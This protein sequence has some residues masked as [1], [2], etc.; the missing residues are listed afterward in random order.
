MKVTT[1]KVV[2]KNV[3]PGTTDLATTPAP[4]MGS[5]P[6][7][8]DG[9]GNTA[10]NVSNQRNILY[11]SHLDDSMS[12][13]NSCSLYTTLPSKSVC[14]NWSVVVLCSSEFVVVYFLTMRGSYRLVLTLR[15]T[16][17]RL[18]SFSL[19]KVCDLCPLSLWFVPKKKEKICEHV[20]TDISNMSNPILRS[21]NGEHYNQRWRNAIWEYAILV[22][23]AF[24][25]D[26][27]LYWM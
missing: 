19:L 24:F 10:K 12:I 2:P 25:R 26:I 6:V 23:N 5:C 27:F 18:W 8:L 21:Q 7:C 11:Y 4:E 13:S 9:R 16:W 3:H 22:Y 17:W 15:V 14:L 1:E 20:L